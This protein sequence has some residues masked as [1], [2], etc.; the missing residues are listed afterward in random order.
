MFSSFYGS[1]RVLC[2]LVAVLPIFISCKK[3]S[4]PP[5]KE[6]NLGDPP[7]VI[8]VGKEF[9]GTNNVA[10]AWADGKEIDLSDGSNDASANSVSISGNDTYVA[11]NDAGPV[12]WKNGT[13]NHLSDPSLSVNDVHS[14]FTSGSRVL[15]CGGEGKAAYWDNGVETILD[16][17]DSF[18]S[19]NAIML[20]NND[21]YIAGRRGF[22][23]VYWKNGTIN[24]L[25]HDAIQ[26]S[27]IWH[28]NSI[29]VFNGKVYEVGWVN[30]AG[31]VFPLEA[32]WSDGAFNQ[33][34]NQHGPSNWGILYDIITHDNSI[35]MAGMTD[36]STSRLY[37]NAA[38]WKD[39]KLVLLP[40]SAKNSFATSIAV[41][42]ND[43]YVAGY[44]YEDNG[45]KYA[46]YWKNGVEVKLSD[47]T[48]DAYAYAIDVR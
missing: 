19:A 48:R 30:Q 36:T 28:V 23:A 14:I 40:N 4:L 45:P 12:F 13:E 17:T 31:A 21:I 38:Y 35:Y 32:Y 26:V 6:T 5:F 33:F 39:D 47:G 27:H 16:Q 22:N 2:S 34:S 1:R 9:N 15:I 42:G 43:I 18:S 10:K 24:Y 11:G 44:E 8:V 37:Y 20:H 3:I 29:T 46:V 41:K 7:A 25:T